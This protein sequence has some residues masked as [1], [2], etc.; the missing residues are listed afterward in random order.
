[1]TQSHGHS[2]FI[3]W[4]PGVVL[5]CLCLCLYVEA[6]CPISFQVLGGTW[7][8]LI[9]FEFFLTWTI[10]LLQLFFG[11]F[12]YGYYTFWSF[13][14]CITPLT[15][16]L[17]LWNSFLFL[18]S[19]SY[20]HVSVVCDPLGLPRVASVCMSGSLC[21][22]AWTSYQWLYH[23]RK[24]FPIPRQPLATN[25]SSGRG[26]GLWQ[27]W[28]LP[29]VGWGTQHRPQYVVSV[30]PAVLLKR[31]FVS[32][33]VLVHFSEIQI[34]IAVWFISMLFILF[35][36]SMQDWALF[37]ALG[38]C[39]SSLRSTY[40]LR[41][42]SSGCFLLFFE[43]LM[44][45]IYKSLGSWVA[46]QCFLEFCWL[47]GNSVDYLHCCAWLFRVL[48]SQQFGFVFVACTFGVLPKTLA[49]P[50]VFGSVSSWIY[51]S[52]FTV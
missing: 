10:I 19:P 34:A 30:F 12:I 40:F 2:C 52:Y 27:T 31:L 35:H 24:W 21:T 14:P 37:Y 48:G 45:W 36:W 38:P 3:P 39:M 23:W 8:C 33:M 32:S 29:S 44:L 26:G 47:S 28:G 5:E 11:D 46:G 7:R 9:H 17:L 42:Y 41:Q 25:R 43:F 49:P 4:P 50:S 22:R 1:M 20:L 13:L 51:C 18:T 6:F 15:L 16:I